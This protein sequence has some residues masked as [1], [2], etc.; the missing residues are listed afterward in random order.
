MRLGQEGQNKPQLP[1]VCLSRG[2]MV[3]PVPI[4]LQ[5]LAGHRGRSGADALCL[6]SL[7]GFHEKDGKAYCRK[8]Y[9]DMF[10]PKCGGCARAILENYISALN[11][12]WHPECFVCRVRNPRSFAAA[13][14]SLSFPPCR[15]LVPL[16]GKGICG[17]V[18]GSHPAR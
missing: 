13:V 11:T 14:G 12:L 17:V 4:T 18:K 1:A 7:A 3:L 5:S 2:R 10:A 9:F 16:S 15:H 6:F 8:D